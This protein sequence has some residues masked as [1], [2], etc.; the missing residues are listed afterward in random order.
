MPNADF[1]TQL[2]VGTEL[3]HAMGNVRAMMIF[4]D[5][6]LNNAAERK[7][8]LLDENLFFETKKSEIKKKRQ[9]K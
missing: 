7:K 2:N 8:R 9:G 4:G 1:L 5:E 3:E 6:L